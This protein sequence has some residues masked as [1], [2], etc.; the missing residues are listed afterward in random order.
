[1]NIQISK[2]IITEKIKNLPIFLQISYCY[3]I[4]QF[5]Y[6]TFSYTVSS[7]P[8]SCFNFK[9]SGDTLLMSN[10]F[11]SIQYSPLESFNSSSNFSNTASCS[12][13]LTSNNMMYCTISFLYK[14]IKSPAVAI[15]IYLITRFFLKFSN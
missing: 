13:R 10:S 2:I 3:N 8:S 1:M 14:D 7:L 11:K 5:L 12:L 15:I 9:M 6:T 4:S